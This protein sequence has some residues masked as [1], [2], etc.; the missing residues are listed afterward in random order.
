MIRYLVVPAWAAVRH[1]R[2]RPP[3]VPLLV[4]A[5]C[6]CLR[7]HPEG[8]A[9][10]CPKAPGSTPGHA[11]AAVPVGAAARVRPLLRGPLGRR[12]RPGVLLWPLGG[13]AYV[14][15]P[16]TPRANFI[17]TAAGPPSTCSSAS[18]ACACSCGLRCAAPADWWWP[19]RAITAAAMPQ[20]TSRCATWCGDRLE[21]VCWFSTAVVLQRLFWVNYVLFLFNMVLV[22]FPLDAGR[23]LQ[24]VLWPSSAIARRRC[25][26]SS[27][28]S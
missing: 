1:H 13:L 21:D 12:R 5:S 25:W 24:C 16:H 18:P 28:A 10:P 20:G 22:G 19:A 2:P 6:A 9:A 8:P 7:R 17:T 26:R 14:D 23:M 11:G 27:P 3:A 4:A 15:V